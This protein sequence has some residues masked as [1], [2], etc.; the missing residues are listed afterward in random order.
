[1]ESTTD[2]IWAV[3]MLGSKIFTFGPKSGAAAAVAVRCEAAPAGPASASAATASAKNERCKIMRLP[4]GRSTRGV[5]HPQTGNASAGAERERE[6]QNERDRNHRADEPRDERPPAAEEQPD[7]G[8]DNRPRH[9]NE[10]RQPGRVHPTVA[11]V[12]LGAGG[13]NVLAERAE[14]GDRDEASE[15]RGREDEKPTEPQSGR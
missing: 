1:M 15:D 4:L 5:C 10:N 13:A 3:D 7:Y 6:E 9:R 14:H 11:A 12:R 2:W 8:H